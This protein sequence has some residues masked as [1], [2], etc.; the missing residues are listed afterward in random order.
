[1][2][3]GE[4]WLRTF[5]D[6]ISNSAF[7]KEMI[8]LPC[9][10]HL[11]ESRIKTLLSQIDRIHQTSGAIERGWPRIVA[12][13][14]GTDK[15]N[16]IYSVIEYGLAKETQFSQVLDLVINLITIPSVR[17]YLE[18]LLDETL[19]MIRAYE[20]PKLNLLEYYLSFKYTI[21]KGILTW[22]ECRTMY[23]E[24]IIHFQSFLY[25]ELKSKSEDKNARIINNLVNANI[26]QLNDFNFVQEELRKLDP[27]VFQK[28]KMEFGIREEFDIMLSIVAFTRILQEPVNIIDKIPKKLIPNHRPPSDVVLPHLEQHASC[29][30]DAIL[31]IFQEKRYYTANKIMDFLESVC[32]DLDPSK[33]ERFNKNAIPLLKT[34]T[35][36]SI[37]GFKQGSCYL[38]YYDNLY[39]QF[40][41]EKFHVN[42]L[43]YLAN[44]ETHEFIGFKVVMIYSN[45]SI[46]GHIE[47]DS[48]I[49]EAFKVCI[50]LPHD[51]VRDLNSVINLPPL[52]HNMR[53][54]Q[55][56]IDSFI[57]FSSK[58]KP[59]IT[60]VESLFGSLNSVD[61]ADWLNSIYQK[62]QKTLVLGISQKVID[63][64]V[65]RLAS[66]M[67]I[68][69]MQI[70]RLDLPQDICIEIAL[71]SREKLLKD[72]AKIDPS[73]A[74][75]CI[76]A[77]NYLKLNHP[78][79]K[80]L[81][82]QINL[83]R[84]LEYIQSNQ[85]RID[86]LKRIQAEIICQLIDQPLQ[87]ESQNFENL[88]ILDTCIIDDAD[89]VRILNKTSPKNI[90]IYGNGKAHQRLYKCMNDV[91]SHEKCSVFNEKPKDIANYLGIESY[92]EINAP[93][94]ISTCHFW[95][96]PHDDKESLV[97]GAFYFKLLGYD[98][99]LIIVDEDF[100]EIQSIFRKYESWSNELKLSD[101]ICMR[102]LAISR[103]LNADCVLYFGDSKKEELKDVV[104]LSNL[105]FWGFGPNFDETNAII[106]L[107]E[108][109]G[110]QINE[111]RITYAI[112]DY[113]HLQT[114]VYHM[115]LQKHQ[116]FV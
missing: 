44:L 81:I 51:L 46:I 53:I 114:L 82:E 45:S 32:I 112:E 57:G 109:F 74:Q 22:E 37:D 24:S 14:T 80:E 1:M 107:N 41:F 38:I 85:K 110:F 78:E 98:S 11:S 21:D 28:L 96:N 48:K 39:L 63:S 90:R 3:S 62:N 25:E 56:V 70:L 15:A 89:L 29:I 106:A 77:E 64:F 34:P 115:Q 73:I 7:L 84:P 92:N 27:D 60:V 43:I 2:M 97:A 50:K 93:A 67:L 68:P 111:H 33:E 99:I 42:D 47:N 88:I 59:S 83:L 36:I 65:T 12:R 105:V 75:S 79:Y 5:Q 49:N 17:L 23:N 52:L 18:P 113:K 20:N 19:F 26:K 76:V 8:G 95:N 31:Q 58:E 35:I 102:K 9:W 101:K 100:D 30:N 116:N 91:V 94:V 6:S 4:D 13:Y 16:A 103:Y 86:Y 69:Q 40:G 10:I 54:S 55:K 61:A 66:K 104:S 87:I 71:K 108:R 72:V